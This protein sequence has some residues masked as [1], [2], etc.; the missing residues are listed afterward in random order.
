MVASCLRGKL[1]NMP[2]TVLGPDEHRLIARLHVEGLSDAEIAGRVAERIGESVDRST[3]RKAR[4]RPGVEEM[5]RAAR[6]SRGSTIRSQRQRDRE[7][8]AREAADRDPAVFAEKVT[9]HPASTPERRY[10]KVR[11]PN[12]DGV[13][14][15]T[16]TRVIVRRA[17]RYYRETATCGLVAAKRSDFEGDVPADFDDAP[18]FGQPGFP[19][20]ALGTVTPTKRVRRVNERGIEVTSSIEVGPALDRALAAGGQLVS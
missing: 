16:G 5:I 9:G 15:D 7:K 10:V 13:M 8:A 17:G 11:R 6:K 19:R 2:R 20:P 18:I 12:A 14:V 1:G 3:I 4:H